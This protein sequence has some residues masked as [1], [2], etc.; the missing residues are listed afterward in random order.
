MPFVSVYSG[1]IALRKEHEPE[2]VSRNG[3][4]AISR[5]P[6]ASEENP[7]W[8]A[9]S[10]PH[11]RPLRRAVAAPKNFP[12]VLALVVSGLAT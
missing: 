9:L 6:F 5:N 1:A 8:E 7:A 3:L 10:D 11:K 4:D 12:Q 2:V